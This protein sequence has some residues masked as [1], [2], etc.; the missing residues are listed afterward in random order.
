MKQHEIA[1]AILKSIGAVYTIGFEGK[2]YHGGV[3]DSA[4]PEIPRVQRRAD[5]AGYFA[6]RA[7][8]PSGSVAK[9]PPPSGDEPLLPYCREHVLKLRV[10]DS[11]IIPVPDKSKYDY[12]LTA[13]GLAGRKEWGKKVTHCE[14]HP[15]G[16]IITRRMRS[17][18]GFRNGASPKPRRATP[19][20]FY[21]NA[22]IKKYSLP[23]LQQLEEQRRVLVPIGDF[24]I[25][26][27][28]DS[29]GAHVRAKYGAGKYTTARRRDIDGGPFIE[30][31]LV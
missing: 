10:G 26:K 28:H 8:T 11:V 29:L 21:R 2:T 17:A 24:P 9:A 3:S 1:I 12:M 19:K 23:Y 15:E 14:R 6:K 5:A 4:S 13:S 31:I 16:I 18:A 7:G 22:E 30:I 27:I 25:K 20:I